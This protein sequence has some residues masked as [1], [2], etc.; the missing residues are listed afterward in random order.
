MKSNIL[1]RPDGSVEIKENLESTQDNFPEFVNLDD[2]LCK[3]YIKKISDNV[4]LQTRTTKEG[5]Y[6]LITIN[7]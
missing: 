6:H 2:L 7:K 5:D 3:R 1:I 4:Y